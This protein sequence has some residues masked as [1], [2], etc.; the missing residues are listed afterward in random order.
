M[1]WLLWML[2]FLTE[3]WRSNGLEQIRAQGKARWEGWLRSDG[4]PG[5]LWLKGA[6]LPLLILWGVQWGAGRLG[7]GWVVDLLALL[8]FMELRPALLDLRN[9]LADWHQETAQNTL[10]QIFEQVFSRVFYRVFCTSFWYFI[11]PGSLGLVLVCATLELAHGTWQDRLAGRVL[12]VLAWLPA[13]LLGFTLALVGNFEEA[14]YAWRNLAMKKS[15]DSWVVAVAWG[16]LGIQGEEEA[17]GLSGVN[18]E[19]AMG[20]EA[21]LWRALIVWA[22]VAALVTAIGA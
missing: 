14:L 1:K 18:V 7:V 11:L 4:F 9:G 2:V 20:V 3:K 12:A 16:A 6:V 13:R 21:L 17:E 15:V 5:G 22:L 10:S 19:M 8:S